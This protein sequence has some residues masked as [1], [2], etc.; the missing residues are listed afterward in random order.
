MNKDQWISS[1]VKSQNDLYLTP[2]KTDNVQTTLSNNIVL[3]IAYRL[4]WIGWSVGSKCFSD[5]RSA[6][7]VRR[8][9]GRRPQ[10]EC[11]RRLHCVDSPSDSSAVDIVRDP[12]DSSSTTQTSRHQQNYLIIFT[13]KKTDY[14]KKKLIIYV[15]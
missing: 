12:P 3:Y 14:L 9:E 6:V 11:Q 5:R 8:Q 1:S 4:A 15:Y 7:H 13:K 2:F 10:E